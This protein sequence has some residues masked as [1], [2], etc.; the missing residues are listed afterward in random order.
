MV[1]QKVIGVDVDGVL[2]DFVGCVLGIYNST[3]W[4]G[5]CGSLIYD[6]VSCYDVET[7][8]GQSAWD[9]I[10][11]II[12]NEQLVRRFKVYDGAFDGVTQ[13]K[14]LGR[15]V[16]VTAPYWSNK[17]WIPDRMIWLEKL[18]DAKKTDVVFTSDKSTFNGD[19]LIDDAPKH[20]ERWVN[21]TGKP[22]IRLDRPWNKECSIGAL[23]KNWP[24]V[25][26]L[27]KKLL[28]ENE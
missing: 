15:V 18:F 25:V 8:I 7:L 23:A 1:K 9:S 17:N 24:E 2:A 20:L 12:D 22:A 5:K 10:L 4:N 13:L 11:N 16:F 3:L 27:S 14:G 19:L 6:D 21:G 28:E 26:E